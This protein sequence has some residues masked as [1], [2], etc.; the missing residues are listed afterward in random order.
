MD[1][2]KKALLLKSI[3]W[4]DGLLDKTEKCSDE[5]WEIL[6]NELFKFYEVDSESSEEEL[7]IAQQK[8]LED[9][10]FI[11]NEFFKKHSAEIHSNYEKILKGIDFNKEKDSIPRSILEEKLAQLKLKKELQN[12]FDSELESIIVESGNEAQIALLEELLS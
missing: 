11:E 1:K 3:Y 7:E 9:E 8:Y 10:K 12:D 6:R 5:E 4:N 2:N